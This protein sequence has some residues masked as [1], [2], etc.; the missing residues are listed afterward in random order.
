MRA[1]DN[2]ALWQWLTEAVF[3][4]FIVGGLVGA[5]IGFGLFVN[6]KFTLSF[7]SAIN[8]YTSM[9]RAVR[10]LEVPRDSIPVV[11]KYMRVIATVFVLGGGYALY[12]LIAQFDA[13]AVLFALDLGNVHPLISG[14]LIDSVRWVLIAGNVAAIVIGIM[15][16]VSPSELG[17]IEE[18]GSRWFS[19]RPFTLVVDR[20]HTPLDHWVATSPRTAGVILGLGSLAVAAHAAW[21]VYTQF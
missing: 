16:F 2:L 12:A 5:F 1:F 14:S 3:V 17:R 9:R 8:R 10:P 13:E 7:L 19:D 11:Q 21:L 20:M 15:M 6:A 4:F 18:R